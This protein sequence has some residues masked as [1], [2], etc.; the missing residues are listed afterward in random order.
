MTIEEQVDQLLATISDRRW[1]ELGSLLSDTYFDYAPAP[2]EPT[3]SQTLV[4]L[5]SALGVALPDLDIR[6][7][8]LS[9]RED[10]ATALLTLEGTHAKPLWGSP[11]SG[12]AIQWT[13]PVTFKQVDGRLAF[14]FENLAFP[15]LIAALRQFGLVNGPDDMDKPPPHPVAIPDFLMKVVMTGQ[16]GDKDCA[17]LD[18]V[19]VVEPQTRVCEPC[20]EE[21][22]MWPALRMCLTCGH[23]GCCDTSRNKHARQH[24]DET[25]HPMIRSI[26]MNEAWAWCY[27]DDAFFEGRT[28]AARAG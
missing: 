18:Q 15:E 16:A 21:G 17:H 7:E 22:V 6:L 11:G 3:A 10:Q 26:R 27:D 12:N 5:I 23:V 25:G 13:A 4:P 28:V 24:H 14:R 2:D 9:A 19:Q 8:D 20:V 1:D